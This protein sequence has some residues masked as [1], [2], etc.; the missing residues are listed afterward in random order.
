MLTD[1]SKLQEGMHSM[2]YDTTY[3]L[4]SL[5]RHCLIFPL[6]KQI[7]TKVLKEAT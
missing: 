3:F 2:M 5:R 6:G 4:K 7:Q 1:K